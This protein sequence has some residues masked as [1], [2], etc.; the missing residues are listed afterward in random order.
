MIVILWVSNV[1]PFAP[2]FAAGLPEPR[3]DHTVVMCRF[4]NEILL[5]ANE[6][7]KRLEPTLGPDTGDLTLRIGVSKNTMCYQLLSLVKSFGSAHKNCLFS[8]TQASLGPS[9]WWS[10]AD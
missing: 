2:H 8:Y 10:L 5:K 6:L 3:H 4:A 9:F 7:V 1:Q